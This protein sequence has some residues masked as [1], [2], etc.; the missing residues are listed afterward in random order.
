MDFTK[1]D[2]DIDSKS[3]PNSSVLKWHLWVQAY[4][5]NDWQ[6]RQFINVRIYSICVCILEK[7]CG[8]SHWRQSE[9]EV[10][11]Q[12]PRHKGSAVAK[13]SLRS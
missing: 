9:K 13:N 10:N 12:C 2:G 4:G 1:R 3:L 11:L 7:V 5:Q 6:G 8:P